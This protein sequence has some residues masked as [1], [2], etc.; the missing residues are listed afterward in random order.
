MAYVA[1]LLICFVVAGLTAAAASLSTGEPPTAT[2]VA[3]AADRLHREQRP[4]GA[5]HAVRGARPALSAR[6]S[7]ATPSCCATQGLHRPK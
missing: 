7:S 5:R 6:G 4:M 2:G 3:R 1:R